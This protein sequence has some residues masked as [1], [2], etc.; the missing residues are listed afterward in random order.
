TGQR[1]RD[2]LHKGGVGYLWV[3]SIVRNDHRVAAARQSRAYKAVI[4]LAPILPTAAVNKHHHALSHSRPG[5]INVQ[6]LPLVL[7]ESNILL[8][9]VTTGIIQCIQYG[10]A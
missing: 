8:A 3:Q 4:I 2:I 6:L 1:Q 5:F 9:T 7:A 10:G